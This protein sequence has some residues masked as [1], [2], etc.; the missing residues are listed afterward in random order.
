MSPLSREGVDGAPY[1]LLDRAEHPIATGRVGM[2]ALTLLAIWVEPSDLAIS[3][4]TAHV[5]PSTWRRSPSWWYLLETPLA[6]F[7][8]MPPSSWRVPCCAG[9]GMG[10]CGPQVEF[11]QL[12]LGWG[13]LPP[14]RSM[15]P[16]RGW[17]CPWWQSCSV[18]SAPTKRGCGMRPFGWWHGRALCREKLPR[19]S[20]IS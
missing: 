15:S 20:A 17:A 18:A 9:S 16:F 4:Q 14:S 19:W 6:S 12:T 8:S 3:P 2:A 13:R 7:S 5:T 11:W 10:C 1:S